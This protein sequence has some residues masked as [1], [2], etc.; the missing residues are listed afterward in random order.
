MPEF[1]ELK[2]LGLL[3][4][5]RNWNLVSL[6]RSGPAPVISDVTRGQEEIS[7][8]SQNG[9][10]PDQSAF[11]A[12]DWLKRAQDAS[13]DAGVSGYYDALFNPRE[14]SLQGWSQS[15]PETTGYIIPTLLAYYSESLDQN[16]LDRALQMADWEIEVILPGGAVRAGLMGGQVRPAVFNTGQVVLG[17]LAAY[18]VSSDQRFLEMAER[19]AAFLLDSL[20]TRGAFSRNLSPLTGSGPKVYNTRAAWA[21]AELGAMTGDESFLAAAIRNVEWALAQQDSDGWFSNNDLADPV[22][23]LTHTIAYSLRGI[24][25]IGLIVRNQKFVQRVDVAAR[26]LA[27]MV[28]AEGLLPGRLGKHWKPCASWSCLTG[29]CQ[30]AIIF[31]KLFELGGDT[32]YLYSARRLIRFA[33]RTQRLDHPS[34]GVRGAIAGSYPVWRGYLPW[35]FPNWATK[36]YL[37]ALLLESSVLSK[38][39]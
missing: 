4:H 12:L 35:T 7:Q 18:R 29:N 39:D 33:R 36:F 22:R 32:L 11:E 27:A 10:A 8:T 31:L 37:D 15:Y 19:S 9:E 28:S 6:L 3:V 16:L 20:D 26:I 17:W 13:P 1:S 25:E 23:P 14:P 24:L 34:G 5:P 2:R 21:L 30:L 38:G